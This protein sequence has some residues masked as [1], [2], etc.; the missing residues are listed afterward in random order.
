MCDFGFGFQQKTGF[1]SK[2]VPFI[3]RISSEPQF[4]RQFG[5]TSIFDL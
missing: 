2:L 1:G 3:L 5:H 4:Y